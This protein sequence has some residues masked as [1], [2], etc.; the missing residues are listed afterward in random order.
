MVYSPKVSHHLFISVKKFLDQ[1]PYSDPEDPEQF[2][3]SFFSV[4]AVRMF[5]AWL[6]FFNHAIKCVHFE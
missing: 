2:V 4:R 1:L 3:Y 5:E 6:L